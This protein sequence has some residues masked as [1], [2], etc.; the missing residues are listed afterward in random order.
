[1]L[2]MLIIQTGQQSLKIN[3]SKVLS[4]KRRYFIHLIYFIH[5]STSQSNLLQMLEIFV[6]SF[7]LIA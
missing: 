1:M 7:K 3:L 2:E 4:R 6:Q 5:F